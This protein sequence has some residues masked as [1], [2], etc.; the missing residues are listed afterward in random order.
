META[1]IHG[2]EKYAKMYN[3]PIIFIDIQ[4]VKR[5]F[6][7]IELST[8]VENPIELTNGEITKLY[9]NKLEEVIRKNP[10]NWL[11]SHR[12]WKHKRQ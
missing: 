2:P 5:G 12:R 7:E 8:L 11:W 10:E 6:Y 4:R 3:Y 1:C 9:M